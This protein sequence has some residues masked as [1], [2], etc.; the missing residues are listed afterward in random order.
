MPVRSSVG[1]SVSDESSAFQ[2]LKL[3]YVK[4]I[5]DKLPNGKISSRE[6]AGYTLKDRTAFDSMFNGSLK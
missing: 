1:P 6:R 3:G 5:I 4:K 2:L